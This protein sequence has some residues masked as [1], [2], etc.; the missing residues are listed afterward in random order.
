VPD[1]QRRAENDKQPALAEVHKTSGK[2]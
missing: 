2:W 1:W